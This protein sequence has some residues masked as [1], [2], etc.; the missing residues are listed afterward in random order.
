MDI[1]IFDILL[2][3]IYF[4]AALFFAIGFLLTATS[5]RAR[6]VKIFLGI[7][8]A[9]F[10]LLV[11]IGFAFTPFVIFLLFQIVALVLIW[12]MCVVAGA[13]CGGGL[14]AWRHR[15]NTGN[16]GEAELG[17]FVPLAEFCR[18][19]DVDEERALARIRSGYY[20]GGAFNGTWYVHRSERSRQPVP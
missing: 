9:L 14:Y 8:A 2:D 18:L 3:S 7:L 6:P 10:T 13:V 11:G 15:R 16:L 19:E 5:G 12:C 17:D 4:L 20:R 1:D